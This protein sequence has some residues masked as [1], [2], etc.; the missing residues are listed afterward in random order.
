MRRCHSRRRAIT[1][2]RLGR[3]AARKVRS[4]GCVLLPRWWITETRAPSEPSRLCTQE[5]RSYCT[6]VHECDD[7]ALG[8]SIPGICA[9]FRNASPHCRSLR[10]TGSWILTRLHAPVRGR[11]ARSMTPARSSCRGAL[12][13]RSTPERI[14]SAASGRQ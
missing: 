10:I 6:F 11:A 3:S 4:V 2:S 5:R 14:R 1:G 8:T 9:P 7:A 13:V 12:A